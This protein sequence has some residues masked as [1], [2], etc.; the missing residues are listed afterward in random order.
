MVGRFGDR[1]AL[2]AHLGCLALIL[3]NLAREERP[4]S[5]ATV[6][7]SRQARDPRVSHGR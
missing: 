4:V 3:G 7:A 6:F 1:Q 2:S 5:N